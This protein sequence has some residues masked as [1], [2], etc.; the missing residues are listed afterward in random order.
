M[1]IQK[2]GIQ[3]NPPALRPQNDLS[4][5]ASAATSRTNIGAGTGS[6]DLLAANNLSDLALASTARTNLGLGD[7]ATKT[8]GVAS[9]NVIAADATGLP[10]IDGS[11]VTGV[12]DAGAVVSGGALG[13]P[14]GGTLTNCTGLPNAGVVGLGTAATKNTGVANGQV[15]IADATGLPAIDGS[16]LTGVV[17][18]DSRWTTVSAAKYTATPAS[19]SQ[20]TMS[21]TSDITDEFPIRYTYNSVLYYGIVKT[22]TTNTS[23]VVGGATLATGGG[24]NDL[25]KLEIGT[26]DMFVPVSLFC[27]GTYADGTTL[28]LYPEDMRSYCRWSGSPGYLV[29]WACTQDGVDAGTE[30]VVT[31]RINA[32]SCWSANAVLTTS[33]TWITAMSGVGA[34]TN[35]Y[36]INSGELF[37]IAV[38][39][40][41]GTGDA[42]DL[43]FDGLFVRP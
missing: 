2:G 7:A 27:S 37:D 25:S 21:D 4:D 29:E 12:T 8:V 20:I 31:P 22:V 3:V 34:C 26:P 38:I 33:G 40:A 9:G 28:A 16:Q 30:P 18:G 32:A 11:Q 15:I 17:S 39:Q 13:T 1:A 19:T 36:D 43:T 42:E 41:G 6:G 10:A 5:V 23:I 24:A 35:L 14:S